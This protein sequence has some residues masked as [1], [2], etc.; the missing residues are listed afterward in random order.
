LSLRGLG[1]NTEDS[2]SA[3]STEEVR[4]RRVKR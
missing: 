3:E 1:T 2:G 4:A